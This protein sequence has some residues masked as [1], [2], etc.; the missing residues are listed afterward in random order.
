MSPL[1]FQKQL[2]LHE[3]RRIL[4]SESSDAASVGRR[5]GYESPSQSS[6]EYRRLSGLPPLQDIDRL[7]AVP[8]VVRSPA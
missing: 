7:R 8:D 4:L 5:V 2:R 3:A 1:Q 6:R